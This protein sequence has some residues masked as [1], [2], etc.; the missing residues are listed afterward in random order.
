MAFHWFCSWKA[1]FTLNHFTPI[2][3][4]HVL[5]I[6]F[7]FPDGSPEQVDKAKAAL[8]PVATPYFDQHKKE[9]DSVQFYY[10][11]PGDDD[12]ADSLVSFLGLSDDKPLVVLV[13]IPEQCKYVCA[14]Q[15]LTEGT[16]QKF[17]DDYL[18]GALQSMSLKSSSW[19]AVVCP[20]AITKLLGWIISNCVRRICWHIVAHYWL[21]IPLATI[22]H[23]FEKKMSFRPNVFCLWDFNALGE[24][25]VHGWTP[26]LVSR[27][28]LCR[29][30]ACD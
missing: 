24:F 12:V 28:C 13:N 1:S 29:P 5:F 4:K 9:D 7:L 11:N 10:S 2:F 17:V 6:F 18:A 27:G 25:L 8:E 19:T 21:C 20:L 15:E 23:W 30:A 22:S 26:V 14:A 3:R 16:V